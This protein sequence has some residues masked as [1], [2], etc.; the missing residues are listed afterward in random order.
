MG[1]P[2]IETRDYVAIASEMINDAR[3]VPM[4][5]RAHGTVPRWKGDARGRWEGAR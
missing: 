5:G 2:D 4:D 3:I 1:A